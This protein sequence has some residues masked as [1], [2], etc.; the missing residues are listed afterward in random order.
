MAIGSY[1]ED[2]ANIRLARICILYIASSAPSLRK[3]W[4]ECDG[5]M[6]RNLTSALAKWTKEMIMNRNEPKLAPGGF[7][8]IIS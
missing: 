8:R 7:K 6:P 1:V 2:G 5:Y 4:I 3:G